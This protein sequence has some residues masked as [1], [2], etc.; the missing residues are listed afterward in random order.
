MANQDAVNALIRR[1]G[2]YG[3]NYF[4]PGEFVPTGTAVG[5]AALDANQIQIPGYTY[6]RELLPEFGG[7][8]LTSTGTLGTT[9]PT[10]LMGTVS[11]IGAG[12][13]GVGTEPGISTQAGGFASGEADGDADITE[14]TSFVDP[15]YEYLS[16]L[17]F[18]V[19]PQ[20]I[21]KT[22]VQDFLAS[23]FTLE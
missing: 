9:A 14:S 4:T 8:A 7:P 17:G 13:S 15:V 20:S 19:T 18:G 12:I 6:Q 2:E 23:G 5:G 1:P 22:H 21:T 10:D 11:S 16:G 3:R